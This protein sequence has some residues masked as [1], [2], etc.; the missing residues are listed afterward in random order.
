MKPNTDFSSTVLIPLATKGAAPA[1]MRMYELPG[2]RLQAA[3]QRNQIEID[4]VPKNYIPDTVFKTLK[5]LA[6]LPKMQRPKEECVTSAE[7]TV[8][9]RLSKSTVFAK[10]PR[11]FPSPRLVLKGSEG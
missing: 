2:F 11:Y 10:A 9:R 6:H 3:D 4:T 7:T 1:L 5:G 8:K